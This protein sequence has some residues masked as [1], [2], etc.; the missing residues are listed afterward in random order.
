MPLSLSASFR[1]ANAWA[2]AAAMSLLLALGLAAA[3]KASADDACANAALREQNNSTGLPDCRAYEMVSPTYKEGFVVEPAGFGF[4]D[5]GV[6]S[7]QSFG[8]FAGNPQAILP[9]PYHATRSATG[10]TTTALAPPDRLYDKRVTMVAESVDLERSLWAMRRRELPGDKLGFWLRDSDGAFTRIGDAE[11]DTLSPGGFRVFVGGSDDL[12]QIVFNHGPQGGAFTNMYEYVGT[13]NDSSARA[14]SVDNNGQT[15]P[16]EICPRDVSDDGRVIVYMAGGCQGPATQVWARVA[17]SAS[18]AVSGSEC[19]R[20]PGD[21]GGECNGMSAAVYEGSANDG[22]RVFFTTSQQLVNGDVDQTQ[23]LYAC[24]IPPG[25]PAGVGAANPCSTLTQV[26]GAASGAQVGNVPVVSEDGSRVYF[27]AVGA[28]LADNLGTNGAAPVAGQPNLYVWTKDAAHPAGEVRF[29]AKLDA[30][31]LDPSVLAQ[32]SSDARYLVFAT[33]SALVT[34]GPGADTDGARDVYRYDFSTRTMVRL[35][36]SVTGSGGNSSGFDVFYLAGATSTITSD[37]STAIFD[38]AEG[39]SASDT[40]GVSDVYAWRDGQVSRIS[41]DGGHAMGISPSGRDIFF[42]TDAQVVA[43]DGDPLTDLYTARVGGGFGQSRP[44]PC[45]GDSCRGTLSGAPGLAAP[46]P[47][48]PGDS[49]PGNDAAVVLS[50]RSVTAAQRRRLAATGK[51]TVTA[52]SNAAGTV[53]AIARAKIGGRSV[54]VGSG[55]RTMTRPGSV[56]VTLK[57]SRKARSQLAA[58]GRLVVRVSVSHSKATKSRSVALKLSKAKA[59]K[60]VRGDRS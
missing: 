24:D 55:R 3:P 49:D 48:R 27:V 20:S 53:R 50:L 26:S 35:S 41:T 39:L 37:G 19:T 7:Y 31:D 45:S 5:D 52:R 11:D 18:V 2:V 57:L 23:D 1:T 33:A 60:S 36:T 17:A 32:L 34:S 8:T 9:I 51:I 46:S 29:V 42:L 59:S 54:I 28:A 14:V 40:N 25:A 43:A 16:P 44:A 10:W 4:T 6:V 13:G 58:R 22:S 38:T 30:D 12:S 15:T 56:T 21:P 47:G